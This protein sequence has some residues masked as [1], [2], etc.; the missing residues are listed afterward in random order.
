MP[1]KY[2]GSQK[3]LIVTF[4]HSLLFVEVQIETFRIHVLDSICYL[5]KLENLL[6]ELGI[7]VELYNCLNVN[8]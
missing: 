1:T 3:N 8:F 4:E 2:G 7:R 5:V 6:N